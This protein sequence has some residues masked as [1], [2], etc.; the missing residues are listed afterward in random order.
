MH[1]NADYMRAANNRLRHHPYNFYGS[2]LSASLG[3]LFIPQF[4]GNATHANAENELLIADEIQQSESAHDLNED[5]SDRVKNSNS[6]IQKSCS[7]SFLANKGMKRHAPQDF[8]SCMDDLTSR[9]YLAA[10]TAMLL[11][12]QQQQQQSQVQAPKMFCMSEPYLRPIGGV[13]DSARVS[14][15]SARRVGGCTGVGFDE[16][17]MEHECVCDEAARVHIE[18]PARL[19]AIWN[20]LKSVGLLDECEIF[21]AGDRAPLATIDDLLVCHDPAYVALFADD[22]VLS[23]AASAQLIRQAPCRGLALASDLDNPW[24]PKYTALACR[25]AVACCF[26]MASAIVTGKIRNGFAIVRPPGSHAE[27]NSSL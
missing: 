26:E 8:V 12:Q 23:A 18:T 25:A 15:G 27:H 17:T 13:G 20:R 9:Y 24:N 16:R 22:E 21:A 6:R 10:A 19:N 5:D 14:S 2:S 7:A 4:G 11:Q 1:G 3:E